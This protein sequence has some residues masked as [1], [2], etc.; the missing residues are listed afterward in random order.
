ML[1]LDTDEYTYLSGATPSKSYA[2][3][4]PAI[5]ANGTSIALGGVHVTMNDTLTSRIMIYGI[6][7][8]IKRSLHD[9]SF[10]E[11][12]QYQLAIEGNG[13][14]AWDPKNKYIAYSV[15]VGD[16][17][18]VIVRSTIDGLENTVLAE[19]WGPVAWSPS[20]DHLLYTHIN[21]DLQ[22]LELMQID[23]DGSN[24]A[25]ITRRLLGSDVQVTDVTGGYCFDPGA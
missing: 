11:L 3:S 7:G 5:D 23:R 22:S 17:R 2:G 14:I 4:S 10:S 18:S 6:S 24:P 12:Y 15:L 1:N 25:N 13:G 21:R 9:Q 8:S 16:A 20:G 19:G